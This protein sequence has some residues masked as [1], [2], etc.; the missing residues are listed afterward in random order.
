[1]SKN[2]QLGYTDEATEGNSYPYVSLMGENQ[3]REEHIISVRE[4][5]ALSDS[6]DWIK[7][8][9]G[10]EFILHK[11]NSGNKKVYIGWANTKPIA[12]EKIDICGFTTKDVDVEACEGKK[13][14]ERRLHLMIDSV[15]GEYGDI[16]LCNVAGSSAVIQVH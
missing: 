1:M 4:M 13:P 2:A 5:I 6:F 9:K 3:S 8:D 10:N 12:G 11:V 16:Y 7:D 14:H 15:L